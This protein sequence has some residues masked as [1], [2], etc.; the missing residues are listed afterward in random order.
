MRCR[1]H[2][3]ALGYRALVSPSLVIRNRRPKPKTCRCATALS[4]VTHKG[5]KDF[6]GEQFVNCRPFPSHHNVRMDFVFFIP[7]P[8]F[9]EGT[10]LLVN[11]M[12]CACLTRESPR[13]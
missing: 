5:Q 12:F 4:G 11:L 1:A 6:F 8:P 3:R 10:L 9:Y 13:G 7:P 2:W